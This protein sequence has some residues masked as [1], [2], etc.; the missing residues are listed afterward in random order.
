MARPTQLPDQASNAA[1]LGQVHQPTTL[2]PTPETPPPPEAVTLPDG[3]D[4]MSLTGV[5]H[6]PPDIFS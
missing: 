6:L 3:A 1:A 5:N 4:N 2:P